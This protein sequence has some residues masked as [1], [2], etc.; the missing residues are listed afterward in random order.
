MP[1]DRFTANF[2]GQGYGAARYRFAVSFK[3]GVI[4]IAVFAAR[5]GATVPHA[6]RQ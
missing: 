1:G 6:E 3:R 4:G 2:N 5:A